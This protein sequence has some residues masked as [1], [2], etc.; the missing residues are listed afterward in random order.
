MQA[1]LS[2]PIA[3]MKSHYD[4]VVVGS[5]YG[6]GVAASRM[7][8]AGQQV[9]L[10]ERGKELR[11]GDYPQTELEA[12]GQMQVDAPE[13]H[14]GS[15]TGMFD[16]HTNQDIS[17][18]VGCGLGGTSLINANVS[19]RAEPRVF[20]DPRWPEPLRG[21][22]TLLEEGYLRAQEMLRPAPYP[23]N[24]PPLAKL[25]ALEVSARAM[26]EKFY[27]LPIN[28]TFQD[29]ENHVGVMQNACNLCGDCVTGCN[30]SAK[31]TTLMNYLPDAHNHGA[32]I[33][34]EVSVERLERQ[35]GRWVVYY[36]RI[37]PGLERFDSPL[38]FVTADVVARAAGSLGTTE[39]LLRSRNAGLPMSDMVGRH[40]TG[41]GN[42]LGMGYNGDWPV[43]GIGYGSV[44]PAGRTPVGPCITG[45]IDMRERPN[46]DEGMVIEEGVTPGA[47][48]HIMP[49][50]LA[51][52]A[53]TEPSHYRG[54]D[55]LAR[56]AREAESLLLGAHHGAM[57]N[58]Q[59]YLIMTHDHS[60]GHMVLDGDRLRIE[61]PSVGKQPIFHTANENLT[62]ASEA[63]GA[64]FVR[65]PMWR[66]MAGTSLITVHPLGG[67]V[68]GEDAASGA[69][70]HKGQVFAATAGRDVHAGLY[71]F[72]GAILP[73][74]V[75]VNPLITITAVAE[76]TAALLARDRGWEIGY[77]LPS[78]PR[79]KA[80][81]VTAGLE[82]TETMKGFFAPSVT[83][84]FERGLEQG[85]E[86]G[87]SF[88][89]LLNV[90]TDNVIQMLQDEGHRATLTG[91]VRAP[92]ISPGALTVSD[93]HFQLFSVD[94]TDVN[95]R[96]MWYRMNLHTPEGRTLYFEG[97]KMVRDRK[98]TNLWVDTTTLF[99][100][101][102][103]GE[104]PAT[105][106][107]GKGI[108]KIRPEDFIKQ[109][110]TM[111]VFNAA[112]TAERLRL[113]AEFGK[114][115]VG[116]LYEVYGG[117]AARSAQLGSQTEPS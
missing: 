117:I 76:R 52:I 75:G 100:T 107:L 71:V 58:S 74:S 19:L 102:H 1:R 18:L 53:A 63:F 110:T 64:T 34:T 10:L 41:N 114:F 49:G 78:A 67:A 101:V 91:T 113:T 16:F 66:R 29:G 77:Q 36:R 42:V 57:D 81:A 59:T 30:Y 38:L 20:E 84:D 17:V 73:R 14:T 21:G 46:L 96:R 105:P 85:R 8:R 39:I 108:L 13:G 25:D 33:Y 3:D 15:N 2:S 22:D 70:N 82:F 50:A 4:V 31:N 69:T 86:T 9:C 26:G 116:Q 56:A 68:M 37:N 48:A 88:E 93:G 11:P 104:D 24:Q 92:A 90:R 65:N 60:E 61:W 27:R 98:G 12:A 35:D 7:A 62:R 44:D 83:D 97:Y 47:L 103:D 94:P 45:V 6:G 32:E 43:H 99:I 95:A 106:I 40:F 112:S 109:L 28:V 89:F 79:E 5:G 23:A 87:S 80:A 111:Q 72:D 55:A 54:A 115:F 51:A